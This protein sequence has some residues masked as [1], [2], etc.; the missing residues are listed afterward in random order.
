MSI[1]YIDPNNTPS[2]SISDDTAI[3][4][5]INWLEQGLDTSQVQKTSPKLYQQALSRFNQG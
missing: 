5:I 3:R 4:A 2:V 1:K